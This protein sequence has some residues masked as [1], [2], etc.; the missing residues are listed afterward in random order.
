M[1]AVPS[2]YFNNVLKRNME[3]KSKNKQTKSRR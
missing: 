1:V 3:K 2:K